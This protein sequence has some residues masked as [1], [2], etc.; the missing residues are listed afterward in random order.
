MFTLI[1]RE[2]EDHIVYFTAAIVFSLV[3][4]LMMILSSYNKGGSEEFGVVFSLF[5]FLLS[6]V[7]IIGLCA[8]GT[9]QM[10]TDRNRKISAFLSTLPVSR[11]QILAARIIT[12]LLAVLVLLAAPAITT[13]ILLRSLSAEKAMIEQLSL[14]IF[15]MLFLA[16]FGI[17]CTGLMCGFSSSKIVPTLGSLVLSVVLLTI[18]IIKGPGTEAGLILSVYIT[19]CLVYT[20]R[21]FNTTALI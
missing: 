8:L 7:V 21:R 6:A 3:I 13:K 11:N 14:D 4:S 10:Y 16:G 1:K 12:G 2:V 19:S 9:S 5:Y 18:I 20:W 17:Y 15:S